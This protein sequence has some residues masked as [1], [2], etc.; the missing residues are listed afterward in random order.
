[1]YFIRVGKTKVVIWYGIW[2]LKSI[3]LN[4]IPFL[5]IKMLHSKKL[6]TADH[7]WRAH[8]PVAPP[9][10]VPAQG[11]VSP[12]TRQTKAGCSTLIGRELSRY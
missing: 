6:M 3:K 8:T 1:M 10:G 12:E 5:A 11:P 4:K 9:P 7:Q 2:L